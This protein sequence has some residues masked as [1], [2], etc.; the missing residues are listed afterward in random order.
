MAIEKI[1]KILLVRH[2]LFVDVADNFCSVRSRNPCVFLELLDQ[3]CVSDI[4]HFCNTLL[5]KLEH[6]FLWYNYLW[7][8]ANRTIAIGSNI[9]DLQPHW[10]SK[11]NCVTFEC[12]K[13]NFLI[14]FNCVFVFL[15]ESGLHISIYEK[16]TIWKFAD[17]II[18]STLLLGCV[19]KY[20]IR[21]FLPNNLFNAKGN[22]KY[23]C[24][25][26]HYLLHTEKPLV[27]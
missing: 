5:S 23:S 1:D 12:Q 26:W 9:R 19:Q 17:K 22:V 18:A 13:M 20:N 21:V 4:S 11:Y 8:R 25:Q 7:S 6:L 27:W 24:T 3:I 15:I 16:R 2:P 10:A 14:A